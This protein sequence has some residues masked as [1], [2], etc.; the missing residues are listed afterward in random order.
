[1][2]QTAMTQTINSVFLDQEQLYDRDFLLW[3][4]DIAR[5]LR[6]K[7]FDH[8]DLENLTEEIEALGRSQKKELKS[9]LTTLLEHLLK[10][11]Y[12]E[13]PQE[14]NGW[15]R[16]IREQRRQIFLELTDSPSLKNIWDE[17]FNLAWQLS[18]KDVCEEYPNVSFHDVWLFSRDID[19]MLEIK[20][21]EIN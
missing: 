10:R 12:V 3:T 6:V 15:E 17:A 2:R 18:L 21:W 11:L 8:L 9:R 7:D 19:S 14:Y 16:T 1:M 5:K 4:E 20:F 13:M